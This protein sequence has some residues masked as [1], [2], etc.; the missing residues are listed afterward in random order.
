MG[1][2][3]AGVSSGEIDWGKYVFPDLVVKGSIYKIKLTYKN[4]YSVAL[5]ELILAKKTK[6]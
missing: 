6:M 5:E 3:T 2:S 1:T 4:Y